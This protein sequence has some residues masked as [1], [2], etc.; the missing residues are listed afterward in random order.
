MNPTDH[1]LPPGPSTPA[2]IALSDGDLIVSGVEACRARLTTHLAENTGCL[3]D[4]RAVRV[5]D[6]FGLQLLYAA[7]RSAEGAQKSFGLLN[8]PEAFAD[9]CALAGFAAASFAPLSCPLP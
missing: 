6:T 4:L 3:I 9:T 2:P 7:R 8:A 1:T 5:F